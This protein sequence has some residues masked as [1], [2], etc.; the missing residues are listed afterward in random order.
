MSMTFDGR[1]TGCDACLEPKG[2]PVRPLS[3]VGLP[4]AVLPYREAQEVKPDGAFAGIEGMYC[5]CFRRVQ[6]QSH[7]F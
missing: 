6:I 4:H 1:F 7:A 3:R 2:L 5:S